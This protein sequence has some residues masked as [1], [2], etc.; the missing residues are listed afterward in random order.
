[1]EPQ[2]ERREQITRHVNHV[3]LVEVSEEA[4]LLSQK[5]AL[6]AWRDLRTHDSQIPERT[7]AL[8]Q[9]LEKE[10][11]PQLDRIDRFQDD[12]THYVITP[13][14]L[15][16]I[17]ARAAIRSSAQ[18]VVDIGARLEESAVLNELLEEPLDPDQPEDHPETT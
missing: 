1:M 7:K 17:I 8:V 14:E 15:H 5:E 12:S 18:T 11:I 2:G 10:I 9:K 4:S 16:G 3:P 6:A 13:I